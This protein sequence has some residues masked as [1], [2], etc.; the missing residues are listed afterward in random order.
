MKPERV[1]AISGQEAEG[2]RSQHARELASLSLTP[3]QFT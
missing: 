2:L 3:N 1:R